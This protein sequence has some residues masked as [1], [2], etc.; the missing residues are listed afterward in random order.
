MTVWSSG[1]ALIHF[2]GQPNIGELFLFVAGAVAAF[3]AVAIASRAFTAGMLEDRSQVL[4]IGTLHF[5]SIGAALGSVVGLAYA[6]H[7]APAWPAGSFAATS[8]YLLV[9]GAEL[10][11]AERRHLRRSASASGK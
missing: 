1:A 10:A 9:V 11:V 5:S 7:G 6:I 2:H 3:A 4:L 8:V